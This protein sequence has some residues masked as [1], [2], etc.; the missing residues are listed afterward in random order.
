MFPCCKGGLAL[1]TQLLPQPLVVLNCGSELS[2]K[3][4][5]R[6]SEERDVQLL[7]AFSPSV[8]QIR[9]ELQQ[10]RHKFSLSNPPWRSLS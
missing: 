6:I 10:A 1:E 4:H 3:K 2:P 9:N 8:T 7:T 5:P